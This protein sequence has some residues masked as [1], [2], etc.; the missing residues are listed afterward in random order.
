MVRLA[1]LT[2]DATAFG[3]LMSQVHSV[4]YDLT[5]AQCSK[6]S[7]GNDSYFPLG[8]KYSRVAL[9]FEQHWYLMNLRF[10]MTPFAMKKLSVSC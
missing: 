10:A 8:Q 5:S 2:L 3:S 4:D 6:S 7:M 9:A 1:T